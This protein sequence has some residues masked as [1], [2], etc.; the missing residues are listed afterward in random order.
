MNIERIFLW[1]FG[2]VF[3]GG[4]TLISAQAMLSKPYD[5]IAQVARSRP[6]TTTKPWPCGPWMRSRATLTPTCE[7]Q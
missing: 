5:G 7:S 3:I 1:G 4:A 2:A 6:R